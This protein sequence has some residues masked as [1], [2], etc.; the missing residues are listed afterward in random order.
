MASEPWNNT[1]WTDWGNSA[2][3]VW[4]TSIS[5]LGDCSPGH[6]SSHHATAKRWD[7]SGWRPRWFLRRRL[8]V[9]M[10]ALPWDLT[11]RPSATP[12]SESLS[13]EVRCIFRLGTPEASHIFHMSPN[14][15][16]SQQHP[17]TS[18]YKHTWQAVWPQLTTDV[19][20]SQW[21]LCQLSDCS[22]LSDK[23]PRAGPARGCA[24]SS[25]AKSRNKAIRMPLVVVLL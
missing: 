16:A 8:I 1:S 14:P 25:P 4:A 20:K 11:H 21:Q 7:I 15:I 3:R 22:A 5:V 19:L 9:P 12:K 24:Q 23:L 2:S 6:F 17:K 10:E 18:V 13:P